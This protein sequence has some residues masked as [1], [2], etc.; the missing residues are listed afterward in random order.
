[1]AAALTSSVTAS[2]VARFLTGLGVGVL[3][4]T[5]AALVPEFAPREKNLCNAEVYSGIP[6]GS[7]MAA[8]VA[9]AV[10]GG[11]GWGGLFTTAA[12]GNYVCA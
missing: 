9:I 6:A 5:T 12:V 3:V 1:M 4:A 2:G 11:I 10:L 7:L 8:V